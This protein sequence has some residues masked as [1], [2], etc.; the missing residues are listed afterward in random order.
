M[1]E[2]TSA[3]YWRGPATSIDTT[4]TVFSVGTADLV[5]QIPG[6]ASRFEI[7]VSAPRVTHTVTV[8]QM[9]QWIESGS[10]NPREST[11]KARLAELLAAK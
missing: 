9:R 6:P 5:E 1:T 2:V 4:R 11:K 3:G 7:E 8:R 10:S